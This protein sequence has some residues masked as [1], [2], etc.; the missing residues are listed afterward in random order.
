MTR[1]WMALT[2]LL[3][4]G[5][6]ARPAADNPTS[7][8]SG[9]GSMSITGAGSI[10]RNSKPDLNHVRHVMPVVISLDVY[11]MTVPL[12]AVSGNED[13]WKRVDENRVDIATHDL[14]DK[15]GIRIGVGRDAD[16]P[17]FKGLLGKYPTARSARGRTQAGKEGY[18]E[19]VMRA[20]VSQQTILGLDDHNRDWGR[21][22]EKCDDLLAIS[23]VASTH[24]PG[25]VVVK[26]C[27]IVRGLR[28]YFHV[29][30]MNNE[31]TQIE[32]AQ[33]EHLYDMRLEARIPL[34]DFLIVAPSRQS[35]LASSM[36]STFLITEGRTEPT[37][38]VLVIVP[39]AYRIDEPEGVDLH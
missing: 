22:F 15:N 8:A 28:R 12:G 36:G 18:I 29:S 4:A 31:E 6:V 7:H 25:E 10:A 20:G 11:H 33:P 9:H 35:Q 21:T 32:L 1:L 26:V 2:A 30:I 19:M 14:L 23:Y 38:H 39:R 37:E 17:Y 3:L 34:N 5:C 24:A 27:P 16:W 13:F